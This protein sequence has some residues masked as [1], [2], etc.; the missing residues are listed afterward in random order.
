VFNCGSE[1]LGIIMQLISKLQSV[2]LT[3]LYSKKKKEWCRYLVFV[4]PLPSYL[5]GKHKIS[6]RATVTGNKVR[7][8]IL[9][10]STI[11]SGIHG[12]WLMSGRLERMVQGMNNNQDLALKKLGQILELCILPFRQD[13]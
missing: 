3:I 8:L 2:L 1:N 6:F 4:P 11:Y 9:L 12:L 7:H 5:S 13:I 10:P